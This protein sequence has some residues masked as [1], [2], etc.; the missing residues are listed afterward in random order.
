MRALKSES[1][2]AFTGLTGSLFLFLS[3]LFLRLA[4]PE[5]VNSE[6]SLRASIGFLSLTLVFAAWIR[7]RRLGVPTVPSNSLN[8]PNI[9]LG[10]LF[11]LIP[12]I[13]I[14]GYIVINREVLTRP[15]IASMLAMFL[16]ASIL[17]SLV[18]PLGLDLS[19]KPK[20][21]MAVFSSALY[22]VF[23]MAAL[24]RNNTWSSIG[25]F[26][27]QLPLLILAVIVALTFA[28]LGPKFLALGL[29]VMFLFQLY[30]LWPT[31]EPQ[32]AIYSE[33]QE[34]LANLSVTGLEGRL[35]DVYILVYESYSA[36]ET[37]RSYG[38]DN[39]KQEQLL[40]SLGFNV[41]DGVWSV[42][43]ASLA[44]ISKLYTP[45]GHPSEP[46][47]PITSG[48]SPYW[49]LVKRTGYKT[50]ASYSNGYFY[51]SKNL[52]A[53]DS[54]YPELN[55]TSNATSS[56]LIE[57]ILSGELGTE[58]TW[59]A[60]DYDKYLGHKRRILSQE[61][62]DPVFFHTHN[63]FPGHTQNSGKCLSDEFETYKE[64]LSIANEE[65]QVDLQALGSRLQDSIVFIVGDHG[66]YLTL[67]CA[68]IGN[69]GPSVITQQAI[70]DRLGVFFAVHWPQS[71][72][73][74]P[75]IEILQ[76]I[77]PALMAT[78]YQ[79]PDLAEK[80]KWP[81]NSIEGRFGAVS[82]IDGVIRGGPD[83]GKSLFSGD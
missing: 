51:D 36:P 5:G 26:R 33:P 6:F 30:P 13:P 63:R 23:E 22:I 57:G 16:L 46:G 79:S 49:D 70:Q 55:A 44:S 41:Q 76:D 77:F 67:N 12:I 53:F 60:D 56:E 39:S 73:D 21:L 78:V 54:Y 7:F 66:P 32:N 34:E 15:E 61:R 75:S 31:G 80:H 58:Q 81:R 82:V 72:G 9:I 52:P 62:V 11:S 20:Y 43:L 64:R 47:I 10:L 48:Y 50:V 3:F 71:L 40:A 19:G 42:D 2:L 17:V 18:V 37:L 8:A 65:M 24:T 4:I 25:D 29:A 69:F 35:P 27:I 59:D 28:Y 14:S 74:A 38:I 45:F 83:D 68:G 1:N